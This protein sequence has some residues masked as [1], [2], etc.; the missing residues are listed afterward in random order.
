MGLDDQDLLENMNKGHQHI[1][2]M[3]G[4]KL[5]NNYRDAEEELLERNM[6][7]IYNDQQKN[8]VFIPETYL[9]KVPRA[10]D[11]NKYDKKK[12]KL[13]TNEKKYLEV[14]AGEDIKGDLVEL[15][16]SEALKACMATEEVVVLQGPEFKT[17]GTTKT[18][19]EEHDF[20]IVMKKLKVI[21]CIES[22]RTLNSSIATKSSNQLLGMKKLIEDYFG[23]KLFSGEWY[24]AAF[25][26]FEI[27]WP[28]VCSD[29]E[30]FTIDQAD[31]LKDKLDNMEKLLNKKRPGWTPCQ[32]EYKSLVKSLAFTVLFHPLSTYVRITEDV[33]KKI[34]GEE[35]KQKK[36][37]PKQGQ[38]DIRSIVFWSRDQA[39]LMLSN[40]PKYQ[41]VAF[42]S[43]WST[44][45]TL[46][47]KEMA[48]KCASEI[49]AQPVYF[50]VMRVECEKT[51]LL[52]MELE[53]EFA[54]TVTMTSVYTNSFGGLG[55]MMSDLRKKIQEKP[56]HWFV[57]ELMLPKPT[58]HPGFISELQQ[59]V[60]YIQSQPIPSRLWLAIAGIVFG[61]TEHV[62]EAYMQSLLA[63]FYLPGL[64][65]PLRSTLAVLGQA[66]MGGRTVTKEAGLIINEIK[67]RVQYSI[68]RLLVPGVEC[69]TF[70]YQSLDRLQVRAPCIL[71]SANGFIYWQTPSKYVHWV[72]F[73]YFFNQFPVMGLL[74]FTQLN[75]LIQTITSVHQSI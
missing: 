1:F 6:P 68:P 72:H 40:D 23:E 38:G 22:K 46:C 36:K 58:D 48:R 32:E 44:G 34:E 39:D 20:V 33:R 21:V 56:G 27:G 47:M 71:L 5:Y 37:G 25:V 29:C 11:E 62:S 24:Y 15:S 70:T 4:G 50:C 26:H 8:A 57:D 2:N 43:S 64:E 14:K 51:T 19:N 54:G 41:F 42:V 9:P 59:L 69:P 7:E 61:E 3:G 17:P 52:E 66:G 16:L 63:D 10:V 74:H 18:K 75:M 12:E 49:P 73:P 65:M 31:Q 28:E 67:C 55:S 35:S 45:K 13:N 60:L 30:L 53:A